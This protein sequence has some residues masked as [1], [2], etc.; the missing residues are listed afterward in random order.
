[1]L[2]LAVDSRH[3]P[4]GLRA[5]IE[6]ILTRLPDLGGPEPAPSLLHG[7]A[8]QNNFICGQDGAV[9]ID[10]AAYFGHAEVD[11]ALLDY[12]Q[13]VPSAVFDGYREI[14]MIDRD[15]ESRRELW[16]IFAYLAVISVVPD[17]DETG[18]EFRRRL[19]DAVRY[20]T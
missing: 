14:G 1:M 3:L 6:R 15:F 13:P 19:V 11:L 2:R 18:A 4:A 7:D 5:G 16:R 9:I 10:S 17:H 8:Q 12:F 20:L